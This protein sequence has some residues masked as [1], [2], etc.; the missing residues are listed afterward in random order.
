M[1]KG[2]MDCCLARE[3]GFDRLK[4]KA[5]AT[6]AELN[7]LKAWKEVQVK[8]LT[9]TKKA[10][11]ESKSHAGKLW[12]V[13]LD[14][15]GEITTLREQVRRAKADEKAESRDSDCFL[16]KF[17]DWYSDDFDECLCQVKALYPDLNVS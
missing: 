5:K 14:K 17:S 10:L 13:F 9:L 12:K 4:E 16:K 2:S 3:K 11:E 7:E 15:E 6:E 8:K 1:M